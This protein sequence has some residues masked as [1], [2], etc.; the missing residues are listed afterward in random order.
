MKIIRNISEI[1]LK[2]A[3]ERLETEIKVIEKQNFDY[4]KEKNNPNS[5]DYLYSPG[6]IDWTG[7]S[8]SNN[9]FFSFIPPSLNEDIKKSVIIAFINIVNEII[10]TNDNLI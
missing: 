9:S 1:E 8:S 2:L 3:L 4:F 5:I 6:F 10:N 7:M